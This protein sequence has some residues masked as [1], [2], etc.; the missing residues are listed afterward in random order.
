MLLSK[1][2]N[3][4]E[5]EVWMRIRVCVASYAY[6]VEHDSIMTDHEFDDMCKMIDLSID[7]TNPEM[8]KWFREN[9]APHTG[10][11]IHKHP[12]IDGIKRL[13]RMYHEL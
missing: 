5:L 7:T 12:H 1:N 13:Y 4:E 9:F 3:R 10:C 6:E 2:K 8:D 11:W